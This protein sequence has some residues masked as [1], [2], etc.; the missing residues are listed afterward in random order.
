MQWERIINELR[1]T[2]VKV[3]GKN[4][5]SGNRRTELAEAPDFEEVPIEAM[6]EKEPITMSFV[7][8]WVGSAQ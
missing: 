7:H 2:L 8:Q 5:D 3:F 4:S 1:E 6:I